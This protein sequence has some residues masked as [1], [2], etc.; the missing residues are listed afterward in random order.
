IFAE[1][2]SN[3]IQ[4]TTT[5]RDTSRSETSHDDDTLTQKEKTGD[6]N[7]TSIEINKRYDSTNQDFSGFN[8]NG[9]KIK[10]IFIDDW[11]YSGGDNENWPKEDY[12]EAK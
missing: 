7:S 2:A 11:K 6:T 3:N 4:S 8:I 5:T 10:G 12:D 9:I 1:N